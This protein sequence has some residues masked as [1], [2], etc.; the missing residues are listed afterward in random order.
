MEASY[1]EGQGPEGAVA[2]Y[3]EWNVLGT[4]IEKHP[5]YILKSTATYHYLGTPLQKTLGQTVCKR[6]C[7]F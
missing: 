6:I 5:V 2:P 7:N 4:S 1:E 3:M